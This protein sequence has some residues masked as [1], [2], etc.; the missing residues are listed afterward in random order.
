M[1]PFEKRT[2]FDNRGNGDRG[3]LPEDIADPLGVPAGPIRLLNG[4][5]GRHGGFG[6]AHIQ[7]RREKHILGLGYPS[8]LHYVHFIAS[9]YN[10]IALQ[11]NGRLMFLREHEAQRHRLICQWDAELGIWSVTTS[12]PKYGISDIE[13]AWQREEVTV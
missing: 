10:A 13:I 7:A 9:G 12:F 8:I 2:V 5:E 3:A 11:D 4:V 1:L 6:L